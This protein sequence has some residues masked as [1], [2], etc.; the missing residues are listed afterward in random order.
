GA[1]SSADAA[2]KGPAGLAKVGH[3]VVIYAENHSFDEEFGTFPG[4]NG[5]K[6]LKPGQALQRDRDGSVMSVLP[7]VFNGVID[8][9]EVAPLGQEY[10]Q[11]PQSA[12]TNMPNA[13]YAINGPSGFN[14]PASVATRDMYHR[15]YNNQMQINGGKNDKMAAW[16]DSG[17]MVMG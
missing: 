3:I 16:A 12:T 7:P 10:A 1:V 13:P 8:G 11:I 9:H 5:L 4:A 6:N 15:F 17:G 14:L 2:L